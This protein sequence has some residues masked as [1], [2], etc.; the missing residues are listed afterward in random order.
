MA[1]RRGHRRMKTVNFSALRGRVAAAWVLFFALSGGISRA[2]TITLPAP[3]SPVVRIVVRQGAV[4]VR[5]WDRSDVQVQGDNIEQ[6]RRFSPQAVTR[7]LRGDLPIF[8]TKVQS[9]HGAI[10]LPA[11]SFSLSSVTAAD[12][13]GIAVRA[14]S[15]VF[16][17]VPA[18]TAL[19]LIN[20]NRG[21]IAV[22]G[23]RGGTLVARLH[24]GTIA[25]QDFAGSAYLETARGRIL[26]SGSMLDR[27]RAR[28]AIGNILFDNCA[29]REIEVSS[30]DGAVVYNNGTFAPGLARFESQ[31]GPVAI[32]VAGGSVQIGAHSD[33]GH[34]FS[35][36]ARADVRGGGS[37]ARATLG[38]GGP[39]VTA[40][41]GASVYLYDGSLAQHR[42]AGAAWR[43]LRVRIPGAPRRLQP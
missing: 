23:Y 33:G 28:T 43:R 34:I 35:D 31:N 41:S 5:T 11:E 18:G 21:A 29:A 14:G 36:F 7:A 42:K 22:Q 4:T 32:G 16:V 40:V 25:V 27:I 3:G 38:S 20:G 12:H 17:T 24:N 10:T 15:D 9:P 1:R 39:V 19:L 6:A 8:A 13:P 30:V 37:D 26:V 2:A